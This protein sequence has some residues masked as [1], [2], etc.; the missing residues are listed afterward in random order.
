M[1]G[2]PSVQDGIGDGQGRRVSLV[3][4]VLN[5]RSNLPYLLAQIQQ[6]RPTLGSWNLSHV[7]FID[8]GSTD[9]TVELLTKVS[10]EWKEP[11]VQLV[12]RRVR[13]GPA[14]AEIA[15]FRAATTPFVIKMD[16]DGQHPVETIANLVAAWRADTDIVV[17]SRYVPGGRV[18]WNRTRGVISRI[19][20]MMAYVILPSSRSITDPLSGFFMARRSAAAGLTEYPKS[21]KLLLYCLATLPGAHC[22]EVPFPM[23]P[24]ASGTSKITGM[25]SGFITGYTREVLRYGRIAQQT[26]GFGFGAPWS[27][28]SPI[29]APQQVAGGLARRWNDSPTPRPSGKVGPVPAPRMMPSTA[30]RSGLSDNEQAG[31]GHP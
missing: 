11:V 1:Y 21:Y 8:D 29:P 5:E 17:A 13:M 2:K 18:D 3:V 16:A 26:N 12:Q 28:P 7:I 14:S 20:R 25:N 9:G 31:R 23:A 27:S 15:G 10:A 19:A 4:P 6:V 24:R 22:V 30:A